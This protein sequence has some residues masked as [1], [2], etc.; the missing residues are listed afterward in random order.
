MAVSADHSNANSEESSRRWLGRLQRSQ[1]CD[2]THF[3]LV[4]MAQR[5]A[6]AQLL[7]APERAGLKASQR[8]ASCRD[9]SMSSLNDTLEA[10]LA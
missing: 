1:L 2:N 3:P 10:L 9:Y 6:A 5:P 8:N 7:A 4:R